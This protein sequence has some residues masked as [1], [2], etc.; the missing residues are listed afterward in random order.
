LTVQKTR[1]KSVVTL[2]VGAFA[3]KETCLKCYCND[4]VYGSTDLRALAPHHGTFG[5]DVIVHVGNALFVR[6]LGVQ[7]IVDELALRNISISPSKVAFLGKKFIAYL[8]HSHREA[9]EDLRDSLQKRGG[10]VLHVD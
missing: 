4:D 3:A 10:Y 9:R 1:E 6:C 7:E 5:F 8:A 2:D